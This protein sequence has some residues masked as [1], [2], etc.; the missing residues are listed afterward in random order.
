MKQIKEENR[1]FE[2]VERS[3]QL[4]KSGGF[5][6]ETFDNF[7]YIVPPEE[8]NRYL[9]NQ[10]TKN[11]LRLGAFLVLR[12]RAK[13]LELEKKDELLK[14]KFFAEPSSERLN[15]QQTLRNSLNKWKN[16]TSCLAGLSMNAY[17]LKEQSQ[18]IVCRNYEDS[19]HLTFAELR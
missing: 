16:S 4:V 9:T 6:S 14:L 17:I 3:S 19:V 2:E 13:L 5:S 7:N 18:C 15:R 11:V 10:L 1:K 12:L 8:I